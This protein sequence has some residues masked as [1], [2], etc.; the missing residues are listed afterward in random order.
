[1]A[2]VAVLSWPGQG[3]IKTIA[4]D[5]YIGAIVTDA[6]SGKVI[7]E[8]NADAPAYPASVC[9][10][11]TLMVVLDHLDKCVLRTNDM[12][13]VTK[14]AA[15]LGGSQVFL[16]E[17][18][19]FTVEELLYA[20][21]VQSANDAATALALHV[22]GSKDAFVSLM[23]QRAVALGMVHTRFSS[24]HGLPPGV[25]QQPD[26]STARDLAQLSFELVKRPDV[27][28]YC[29]TREYGF[30]GGS[31]VMRTHNHLL[32]NVNGVDG[33]K[34]GWWP[35]AGYSMAI[36]A[37]RAGRRVI[38]V[39]LGSAD[40]LARD[41]VATELLARGFANLPKLPPVQAVLTNAVA[42]SN[43][44]TVKAPAAPVATGHRRSWLVVVIVALGILVISMAV[45][46]Q[47]RRRM[48]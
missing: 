36:T 47:L 24:E 22:A 28:R 46:M 14:E 45:R 48:D 17:N 30:R 39:T 6:D 13:H 3:A 43:A 23:N 27:L 10:L 7:L 25:G 21:I 37:K 31:F 2:V 11:M 32:G 1:M 26:V 38:V 19:Q 8:V 40:R 18:E 44:P 33:L 41:K 16:K 4:R 5:P 42:V 35:A 29:S 15:R 9:K 34:T 20:L 12:V